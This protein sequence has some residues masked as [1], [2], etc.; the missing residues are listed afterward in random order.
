M[1][2]TIRVVYPKAA[3]GVG[4]LRKN[5][6]WGI[7]PPITKQSVVH[8]SAAEASLP[9]PGTL[10][11]ITAD[12]TAFHLGEADVYVTNISPHDGGVEFILHVN[13]NSPLDIIVDITVFD[14]P[15]EQ[16]F[17]VS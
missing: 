17:V 4:W 2:R 11:G 3:A 1:P 15:I 7:S 13:F 6:N 10:G 9:G 14:D 8:V 16:F 5:F 12:N